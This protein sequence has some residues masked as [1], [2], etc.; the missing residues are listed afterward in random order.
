[1]LTYRRLKDIEAQ[2]PMPFTRV[3]NSY[4]VNMALL[5]KIQDNHIHIGEAQIPIG[6]KFKEG[7]MEMVRRRTI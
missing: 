7:V 2:L 6:E 5:Q 3:H 1:M 4:I